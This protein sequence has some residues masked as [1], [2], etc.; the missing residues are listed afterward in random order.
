M[1]WPGNEREGMMLTAAGK[2][3]IIKPGI[4]EVGKYDD[5][6]NWI[7]RRYGGCYRW[8]LYVNGH[9]ICR[10]NGCHVTKKGVIGQINELKAVLKIPCEIKWQ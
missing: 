8:T 9:L 1:V 6:G 2:C 4:I 10:N 3:E 7:D 5:D